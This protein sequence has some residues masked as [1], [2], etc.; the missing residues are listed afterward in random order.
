MPMPENSELLPEYI[1]ISRRTSTT[2]SSRC[3]DGR[4]PQLQSDSTEIDL[5]PQMLGGVIHPIFLLAVST[6][7]AFNQDFVATHVR[8]LN[9]AGLSPGIHHGSHAHDEI[10]D[11]G[12]ADRLVGIFQ[13]ALS[14]QDEITKR[15]IQL[16]PTLEKSLDLAFTQLSQYQIENI[17]LTG[18]AL[19]A[20]TKDNGA[21]DQSLTSN[22]E[23]K[24]AFLN[25]TPDTTFDTYASNTRGWQGFNLDLWAVE[26]YASTL[27]SD[28]DFLSFV[29][30]ASLILY[31]ATEMVLVENKG[32]T[33]LKV[34]L[35]S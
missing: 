10:S 6:N 21:A 14:N 35:H 19:I 23:E 1:F 20:T 25:L 7:S 29:K 32:L 28:P 13:T 2:I 15:L 31:Q 4:P 17:Q 5:G 8:A 12:F 33:P 24:I 11:C 34:E 18:E 30:A 3:V 26:Q 22:H 27:N 9:H 16:D